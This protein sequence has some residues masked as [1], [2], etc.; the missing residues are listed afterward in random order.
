MAELYKLTQIKILKSAAPCK[1]SDGGGLW[2]VKRGGSAGWFFR[3]DYKTKRHEIGIGGASSVT[4]KRAREIAA[5]YRAMKSES[6]NPIEVIRQGSVANFFDDL[7]RPF[8]GHTYAASSAN[9]WN[10]VSPLASSCPLRI[11]C[12]VSIPASVASAE[13]KA[14]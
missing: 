2:L 4:L 12:A 3:Y 9:C 11:M 1:L 7:G 5:E 6:I 8:C 14:L 10:A 13:W